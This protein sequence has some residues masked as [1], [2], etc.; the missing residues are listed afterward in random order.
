MHCSNLL[1]TLP[2]VNNSFSFKR[3]INLSQKNVMRFI[4][5]IDYRIH[6]GWRIPRVLFSGI[7][8]NFGNS[9]E[10]TGITG[11]DEKHSANLFFS[12]FNSVYS[13]PMNNSEVS[14]INILNF[15]LPNNCYFSIQDVFTRLSSLKN[16]KSVGLDGISGVFLYNLRHFLYFPL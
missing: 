13:S 6:H 4:T 14:N 15:D 7:L 11:I 9:L 10:R 3:A 12:Y 16:V 8:I 5:I 1:V 2:T